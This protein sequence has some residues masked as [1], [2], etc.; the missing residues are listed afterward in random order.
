MRMYLGRSDWA[1][2]S[3]LCNNIVHCNFVGGRWA[4]GENV[5]PL[6]SNWYSPQ[7]SMRAC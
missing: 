6:S 7:V 5:G 2:L 4:V 3:K 1:K